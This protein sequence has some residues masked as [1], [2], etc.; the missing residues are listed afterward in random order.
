MFLVLAFLRVFV[1]KKQPSLQT[2]IAEGIF[3]RISETS[4]RRSLTSAVSSLI[5]RA[6]AASGESV[7]GAGVKWDGAKSFSMVSSV[8]GSIHS[9]FARTEAGRYVV[10]HL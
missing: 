1:V 2:S 9:E 6:I 4:S 8:K 10:P 3:L 5:A 7:G